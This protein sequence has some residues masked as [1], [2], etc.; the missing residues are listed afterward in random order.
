MSVYP[1]ILN[2]IV[3]ENDVGLGVVSFASGA[4]SLQGSRR[5]NRK[6]ESHGD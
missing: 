2:I 6:R 5:Y 3:L 1:E 4:L